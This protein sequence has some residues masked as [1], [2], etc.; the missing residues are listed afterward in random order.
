MDFIYSTNNIDIYTWN[1]WL[2]DNLKEE[3]SGLGLNFTHSLCFFMPDIKKENSMLN[4]ILQRKIT[5]LT[6][7]SKTLH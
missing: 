3:T 1:C 5:V 2:K 7:P 4:I 6:Y